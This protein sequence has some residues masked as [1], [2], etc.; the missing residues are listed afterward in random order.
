[1]IVGIFDFFGGDAP[2]TPDP[3]KISA[4]QNKSNKDAAAY[5]AALNRVNQTSP[6]G[7][8]TWAQSG[9]DPATGAPIYTQNTQLSAPMQNLF[10]A[11]TKNQQ[12]LAGQINSA[13]GRIPQ[14]FDASGI[15]TSNIAKASY[16]SAVSRMSPQFDEG[17]RNLETTMSDRGIPIGSEVWNNETTRYDTAKGNSLAEAARQAE[18]SAGQ[19]AQR[20]FG[21]KVTEYQLPLGTLSTLQGMSNPVTTPTFSSYSTPNASPADVSGNVWNAYTA[22]QKK[23]QD[24]QSNLWSGIGGIAKLGLT[25]F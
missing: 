7:S 24:A 12:G 15:D 21:N 3:Y 2:E 8:L 18:L 14:G 16:D 22:D 19:E 4:D 23:N 10:N 1:L 20:Q 11:Q 13:L 6:F 17:W 5:S 9:T 25:A